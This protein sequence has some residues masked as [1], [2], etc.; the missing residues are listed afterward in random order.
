MFYIDIEFMDGT[1]Q[2]INHSDDVVVVFRKQTELLKDR[3][4]MKTVRMM[5]VSGGELL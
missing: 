2:Q 1:R 4:F 3:K 5:K